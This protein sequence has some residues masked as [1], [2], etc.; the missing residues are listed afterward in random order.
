MVDAMAPK[1]EAKNLRQGDVIE[2]PL[3][4]QRVGK[5]P[6]VPRGR[7]VTVEAPPSPLSRGEVAVSVNALGH[8]RTLALT[9]DHLVRVI[10]RS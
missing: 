6:S 7:A 4:L 5:R 8:S 2:L 10:E 3:R 1:V 9:E